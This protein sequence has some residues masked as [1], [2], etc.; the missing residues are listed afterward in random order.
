MFCNFLITVCIIT[1]NIN[2]K[3]LEK[4]FN[5]FL[6]ADSKTTTTVAT[7]DGSSGS[8]APVQQSQFLGVVVKVLI[9]SVVLCVSAFAIKVGR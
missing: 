6:N 4:Y 1:V 7:D 3:K 5:N 2:F 9:C 8:N